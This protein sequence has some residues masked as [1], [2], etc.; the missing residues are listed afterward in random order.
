M[1]F[2]ELTKELEDSYTEYKANN[3]WFPFPNQ[4]DAYNTN[5]CWSAY[6]KTNEPN[7]VPLLLGDTKIRSSHELVENFGL[8]SANGVQ[9]REAIPLVAEAQQSRAFLPAI[10]P[11]R[12]G[13]APAQRV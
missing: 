4:L 3:A 8:S 12:Q 2:D 7:K 5:S 11:R 6:Q 13:S 9:E 10:S 1:T